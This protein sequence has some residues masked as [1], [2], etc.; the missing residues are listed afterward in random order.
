VLLSELTF[1]SAFFAGLLGATHCIGMCGSIVG[2]LTMSLPANVHQSYSRLWPYLLIYNLGRISSY[3]VA[4]ILVGLLGA[5]FVPKLSL[6]NP[7]V[8][9]T[10]I[11]GLFVIALG[12]YISGW[13]QALTFLEKIGA[14]LWRR[15]EPFGRHFLP[16]KHPLQAF[17]FGLVWGWLPCGL[18]YS[19]LAFSLASCSAWQGGLLMLAFGLGT[20][21]MSLAMG[22]TAQWLTRFA[23]KPIVRQMV[24]AIVIVFGLFIISDQ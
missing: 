11:S 3:T 12:L 15:I 10:W 14:H 21:P 18:V 16:V 17:G 19:I 20:L 9:M 2:A 24:G 8:V 4:G 1:L 6:N 23:H 7:H 13:W 22:V 5:V